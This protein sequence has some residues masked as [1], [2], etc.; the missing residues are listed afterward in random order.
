VAQASTVLVTGPT[1]TGKE[2]IA[3][4]LHAAGDRAEHPF[5][6]VDCAAASDTLFASQLFGHEKGAF[7]G[8]SF[9]SL[10]AFR[11]ADGGTI[12]LDEIGELDLQLQAKLLRTLQQ[13]VVVP[14]G[15]LKEF[16]IDA[17]VVA[18]TNRDLREEVAAGR[19]REDLYYRLNVVSLETQALREHPEDV[20]LLVQAILARFEIQLGLGAKQLSRE[21]LNV[22]CHFHWPGNVRQLGNVL[23]R[24]A[25]F[26]DSTID[27]Q[28]L[29]RDLVQASAAPPVAQNTA[30][31]GSIS[32][33]ETERSLVLPPD[34]YDD[35]DWPSM[36][37]V[38]RQHLL[39]TLERT[40]FNQTAAARLLKLDRNAVRRLAQRL[41]VSI[42]A[43]KPR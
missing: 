7:T 14:I 6:P 1:G 23:E 4:S 32:E 24:A 12:F 41:G 43:P 21:A 2:L 42:A 36:E 20:P 40:S 27:I 19:F 34:D 3:R 38:E 35:A 9:Q 26:S 5:V 25:L 31:P 30:T 37:D 18:A 13:R 39:R 16:P 22:L 15:G 11:A 17:R 33:F 29:P 8:A 10:G 28:H